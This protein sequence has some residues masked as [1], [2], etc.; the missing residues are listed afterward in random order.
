MNRPRILVVNDDGYQSLGI[1][2]VAKALTEV[3]DVTV[4]APAGDRSGVGHSI[5]VFEPVRVARV[6]DAE[7]P[8]FACSGTPADCVVIGVFDLCGARPSLIVSGINRGSNL[9]DDVN[10]SGTVAAAVEGTLIGVPSIAIS[11]TASWP[12]HA[13]THHWETAAAVGVELAGEVLRDSLP[14]GVLLNVNVPN[15]ARDGLNGTRWTRLGRKIY[16]DRVDMRADP[17]GGSYYW[18]WG[19]FDPETIAEGTDLKAIGDLAVSITPLSIQRTDAAMLHDRQA[20]ASSE[21]S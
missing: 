4:V 19:S 15:V 11:L 16:R 3:G 5:S 7:V 13:S 6:D 9:G 8:T 12:K 10:Y 20:K 14:D 2:S 17:R 18:I 21:K 1:T